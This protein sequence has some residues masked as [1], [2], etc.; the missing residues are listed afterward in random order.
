MDYDRPSDAMVV[1]RCPIF[2]FCRFSNFE[3]RLSPG[4]VLLYYCA[5][6]CECTALRLRRASE[7]AEA[8]PAAAAHSKAQPKAPGKGSESSQSRPRAEGW[9]CR[10]SGVGTPRSYKPIKSENTHTIN[11]RRGFWSC[12]AAGDTSWRDAGSGRRLEVRV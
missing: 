11:T 3:F 4:P 5:A 12:A 1:D 7:I 8:T 2:H 10:H 6:C 9:G